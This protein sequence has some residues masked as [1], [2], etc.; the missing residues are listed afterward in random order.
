MGVKNPPAA[1]HG[2]RVGDLGTGLLFDGFDLHHQAHVL[3][4]APVHAVVHAPLRAVDGGL[5]VATA[6]F[7]LEHGALVAVEL[8]GLEGHRAGFAQQRE[9]AADFADLVAVEAELVGNEGDFGVL[10]G[11]EQ[12]GALQ[13]LVERRGA[14]VDRRTLPSFLSKRPRL[15]EAPKW[16]ISK[17][18][19][20]CVGS[21][22]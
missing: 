11:V 16:L 12:V 4:K 8:V 2:W 9:L 1:M 6:D 17:V 13:V 20:V 3:G 18:T 10:C 19:K 14:G 22:A 21:M 7:A 5:E 15:T